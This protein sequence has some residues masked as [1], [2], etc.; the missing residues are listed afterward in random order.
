MAIIIAAPMPIPAKPVRTYE[1]KE[2]AKRLAALVRE[3]P[4]DA[5]H[6]AEFDCEDTN[7]EA[8]IRVAGRYV[9]A[10]GFA[11]RG[12]VQ[13]DNK[14]VRLWKY[15]ATAGQIAARAKR[16]ATKVAAPVATEPNSNVQVVTA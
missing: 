11:I 10:D 7:P 13:G 16:K 9:A 12:Q 3:L 2:F 15:P 8:V 14:T 4:G 1:P 6:C 5:K